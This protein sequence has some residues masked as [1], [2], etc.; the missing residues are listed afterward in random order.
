MKAACDQ[1]PEPGDLLE[2][3]DGQIFAQE[4]LNLTITNTTLPGEGGAGS[5]TMTTGTIVGIAVGGGLFLLGAIA[6]IVVYYRR[7]KKRLAD[8]AN[9]SDQSPLPHEGNASPFAVPKHSPLSGFGDP[10]S[11][12]SIRSSEYELREKQR[13]AG[14]ADHY[15]KL[16]ESGAAASSNGYYHRFDS[17]HPDRSPG[18]PYPTTYDPRLMGRNSPQGSPLAPRNN[19]RSQ[20]PE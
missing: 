5:A 20:A 12:P 7:R 14:S 3:G 2:L 15:D 8:E 11:S 9:A 16:D 10:K 17:R 6:I 13:F 1:E 18:R 19:H 4:L